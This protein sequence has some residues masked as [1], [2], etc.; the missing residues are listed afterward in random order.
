MR[1]R[2]WLD[3]DETRTR[4]ATQQQRGGMA[5]RGDLDTRQKGAERQ[6]N[7]QPTKQTNKRTNEQIKRVQNEVMTWQGEGMEAADSLP[8]KRPIPLP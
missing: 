1:Q 7:N 8:P 4:D 3:G 6:C 2:K 5:M